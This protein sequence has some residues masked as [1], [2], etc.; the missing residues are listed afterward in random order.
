[1]T[2]AQQAPRAPCTSSEM[3]GCTTAC[4]GPLSMVPLPSTEGVLTANGFNRGDYDLR[5]GATLVA[6]ARTFKN[7]GREF[8]LFPRVSVGGNGTLGGTLKI[9]FPSDR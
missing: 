9:N 6:D 5:S 3:F 7:A 4:S 8:M 2:A 1:N